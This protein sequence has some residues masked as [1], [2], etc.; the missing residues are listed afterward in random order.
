MWCDPVKDTDCLKN[1]CDLKT[2]S[3]QSSQVTDGAACNDGDLCTVGDACKGGAC[4][5]GPLTCA[6]LKDADCLANEDGNPCTGTLY[7]D[8]FGPQPLCKTDPATE[9]VCAAPAAVTC[10]TAACDAKTGECVQATAPNG[11]DCGGGGDLSGRGV[12]PVSSRGLRRMH[13]Q[14]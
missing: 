3:C 11:A 12:Y 6:C 13:I 10:K 8:L 2:A 1:S 4:A 5:K 7:C 9:V 14:R